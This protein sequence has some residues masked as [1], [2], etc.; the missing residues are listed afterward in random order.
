VNQESISNAR[1]WDGCK[2]NGWG[3]DLHIHTSFSPDAHLPPE[4]ACRAAE[5]RDIKIIGFADHAEFLKK[6]DAYIDLYD[7]AGIQTEI[8]KLRKMYAD[9]L[10]ILYGVEIGY[11]PG[12]E[13]EIK[14]FLDSYPF[15]YA[16]GSV[17]YV[18]EVLVSRWTREQEPRGKSLMPY[19]ETVLAATESG[20]F[21]ILGHLDYVRKYM[22]APQRYARDEYE[23]VIDKILD[24]A[25][26]S[27]LVLEVNTSGWRQAT[28]EPYPE[29]KILKRFAER[30]GRVTIGSDAH[31][32]YEVGYGYKRACKLLQ[33][34]GFSQIEIPRK[35]HPQSLPL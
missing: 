4:F 29:E 24:A 10:E 26:K 33:S 7:S 13:Q 25:L 11:I 19:F 18:D 23:G 15:D 17:H 27:E 32:Y 9:K 12:M 22:F 31:K 21:Q 3:I 16:I 14:E 35:G 5:A 28:E 34:A 30:G 1:S 20:L 2:T 8:S 6:D